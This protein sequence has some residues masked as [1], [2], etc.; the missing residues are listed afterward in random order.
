MAPEAEGVLL[1]ELSGGGPLTED[2]RIALERLLDELLGSLAGLGPRPTDGLILRRDAVHASGFWA[3]GKAYMLTTPSEEPV[4]IEFQFNSARDGIVSGR[5][6]F[7]I[8]DEALN[9]PRDKL[10]NKLLAFAPEAVDVIPWRHEFVRNAEGWTRV[11][12]KGFQ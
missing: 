12:A 9:C 2:A 4:W 5:C 6:L 8:R 10:D 7:G 11:E 1:R 3:V